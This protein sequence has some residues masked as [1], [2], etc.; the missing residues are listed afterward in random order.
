MDF[1][2]EAER[3]GILFAGRATP[4][5]VAPEQVAVRAFFRETQ[6]SLF[7]LPFFP[8]GAVPAQ[9]EEVRGVEVPEGPAVRPLVADSKR[10]GLIPNLKHI[11]VP[12]IYP[13]RGAFHRAA[14]GLDRV[15]HLQ[16]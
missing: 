6:Q 13:N 4:L 15:R 7:G 8:P 2:V 1:E 11:V 12:L 5:A 16:A 14:L 10:G 3:G 9:Q